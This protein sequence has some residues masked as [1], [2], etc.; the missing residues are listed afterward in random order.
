MFT[1]FH[2]VTFIIIENLFGKLFVSSFHLKAQKSFSTDHWTCHFELKMSKA[3]HGTA[4]GIK[5]MEKRDFQ[6][7]AADKEKMKRTPID[8]RLRKIKSFSFL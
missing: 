6:F 7:Y 3:K 4:N 5:A 8:E 2:H 1:D